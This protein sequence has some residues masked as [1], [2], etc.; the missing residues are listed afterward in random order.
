MG[1]RGT[2]AASNS[3]PYTYQTISMIEGVKVL[4]GLNGKHGLPEEAHSSVS[5]IRLHNNGEVKQ[6]RL[7]NQD[8]TA[9]TDIEY[10]IHQGKLSLHAHDYINGIR[11]PARPLTKEDEKNFRKFWNGLKW[12]K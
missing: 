9:K 12:Q 6:L 8:L 7:Y 1:G 4:E 2:F 11:Q 3:V 10:S 5:Y